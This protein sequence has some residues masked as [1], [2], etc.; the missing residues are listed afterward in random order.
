VNQEP[1]NPPIFLLYLE[2]SW[3][4]LNFRLDPAMLKSMGIFPLTSVKTGLLGTVWT[5]MYCST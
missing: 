4:C 3:K 2:T 5:K 1:S